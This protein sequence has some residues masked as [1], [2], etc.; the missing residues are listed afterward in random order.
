M[1]VPYPPSFQTGPHPHAPNFGV[2]AFFLKQRARLLGRS[3]GGVGSQEG[4]GSPPAHVSGRGQTGKGR[5]S[6]EL[7]P[8][9]RLS[10]GTAEPS[11][12][13]P[14]LVYPHDR[15]QCSPAQEEGVL[16]GARGSRGQP[17]GFKVNWRVHP[18]YPPDPS[19]PRR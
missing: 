18:L 19:Q 6:W 17:L 12:P 13:F 5:V 2:F 1:P 15:P 9:G 16:M 11:L 7:P 14:T 4:A 8:G 10:A 3:L